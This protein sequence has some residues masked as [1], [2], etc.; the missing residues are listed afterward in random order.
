MR[1]TVQRSEIEPG[2]LEVRE[3]GQWIEEIQAPFRIWKWPRAFDS[4]EQIYQ[5]LR[6]TEFKSARNSVYRSLAARAHSS[7]DLKRKL[8]TKRF[9]SSVI[10]RVLEELQRL[11]YLED[12]QLAE[13]AILREF[14]RGYG[15]KYIE[16]KL[17]SKGLS[18]QKM[19]ELISKEM[20]EEKIRDLIRKSHFP[21][22]KTIRSLQRR[23]FDLQLILKNF[24]PAR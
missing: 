18:S 14:K 15:P 10:T 5:W 21:K 2:Y 12:D 23:G 22:E 7:S 1:W 16:L 9:S 19:R 17:R 6:E 3:D 20:E 4:K 13:S 11:G 24:L 8:E